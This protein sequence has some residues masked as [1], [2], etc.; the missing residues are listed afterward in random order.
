LTSRPCTPGSSKGSAPAT[1]RPWRTR[2]C[3]FRTRSRHQ[4]F[5]EPEGLDTV[6][7]YPNGIPTS[8][9]LQTQIAM[10]RSHCKAWRRRRIIRPGYAIEYDYVDPLELKPSLETKR[11]AGLFLAGQINGTSGL[12]RSRGPGT[13][14]RN[15]RGRSR[16]RARNR[17]SW[18]AP[19]PTSAC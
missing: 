15:Q 7:I 13:H 8:L 12:R 2:S 9:P 1:A 16:S 3:A 19:R 5:L 10:V 18:I 14:G 17:S 4:I 11:V 6:E